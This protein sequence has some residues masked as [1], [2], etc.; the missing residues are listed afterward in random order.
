MSWKWAVRLKIRCWRP[1]MHSGTR[2]R[3]TV[4][5]D[6]HTRDKSWKHVKRVTRTHF[7]PFFDS[8]RMCAHVIAHFQLF[9][10]PWLHSWVLV[11]PISKPDHSFSTHFHLLLSNF[12]CFYLFPTI[13]TYS[14]NFIYFQMSLLVLDCFYLFFYYHFFFFFYNSFSAMYSWLCS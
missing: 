14:I 2:K 8:Y 1:G 9:P 10:R 11:A 12:I 4:G 5:Y 7:Q 13:F 3:L 6:M